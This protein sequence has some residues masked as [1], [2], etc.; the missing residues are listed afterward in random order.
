M[1]S[2]AIR[3]SPCKVTLALSWPEL[4]LCDPRR[5]QELLA[6]RLG[7]AGCCILR[8]PWQWLADSRYAV[9]ELS[10]P[11]VNSGFLVSKIV[12]FVWQNPQ[13]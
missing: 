2:L 1:H 7:R 3:F 10:V 4:T 6:G 11:A 12:F 9:Y 13:S 5:C 8:K